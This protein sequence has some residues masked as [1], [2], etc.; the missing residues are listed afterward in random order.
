M[1][2]R[3]AAA[4]LCLSFLVFS[5][6]AGPLAGLA[7]LNSGVS[8]R[9]SSADVSGGNADWVE[10]KAHST[11]TLASVE[12]AGSIDISGSRSAPQALFT[13]VSW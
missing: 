3:F 9:A 7:D 8:R 6:E 10:V 12:G 4:S 2:F 11:V 1:F 5:Q 13:C